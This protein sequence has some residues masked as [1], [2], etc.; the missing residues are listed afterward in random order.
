MPAS[1]LP[2][3][4]AFSLSRSLSPS[5]KAMSTW[6]FTGFWKTEGPPEVLYSA[7]KLVWEMTLWLREGIWAGVG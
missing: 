4:S 6:N 1:L 7:L 2:S 5:E 3:R